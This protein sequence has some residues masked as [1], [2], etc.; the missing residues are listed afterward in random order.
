V[1]DQR[2]ERELAPDLDEA[3]AVYSAH[4]GMPHGPDS[5]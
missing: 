2:D 3:I 4:T 5:R 1:S